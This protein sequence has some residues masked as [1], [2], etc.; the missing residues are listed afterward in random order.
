MELKKTTFIKQKEK[1]PD[2]LDEALDILIDFYRN[3]LKD[4]EKL[5]EDEFIAV[6]HHGAGRFMRNEW[7]LWWFPN[8][9]YDTWPTEQPK[10]N[11]WFES[12]GI[13]HADDMSG[14]LLSCLYRKV[15]N[16]PFD[17]DSQVKSYHKHW[18]EQGFK[19][20]IPKRG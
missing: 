18:K 4:M 13:V 19:D 12:I 9:T 20:G 11:K 15:K 5:S 16:L 1:L 6:A 3:S 8:H 10:L 2:T 7:C 17:I 14:I